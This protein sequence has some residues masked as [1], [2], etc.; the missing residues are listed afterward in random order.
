MIMPTLAE[1]IERRKQ[2]KGLSKPQATTKTNIP[3]EVISGL[4]KSFVSENIENGET[5]AETPEKD[6]KFEIN[7]SIELNSIKTLYANRFGTT[8]NRTKA[9]MITKIINAWR[10]GENNGK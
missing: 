2:E 8:T 4:P 1:I 6:I 3:K 7:K 10:K 9:H 5:V